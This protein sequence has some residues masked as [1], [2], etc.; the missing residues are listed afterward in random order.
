M[1][2]PRRYLRPTSVA[3]AV[4]L[5]ADL[6]PA[7]RPVAGGT[8]LV[9]A[10]RRGE[11]AP[12][13]LVDLTGIPE[14][15]ALAE[16]GGAVRVG[17]CVTHARLAADPLVGSRVPLLALAA[18]V[19]GSAQIRNLGTLG[20]NVVNASVAADTP[21]ALAALGA[22]AEIAGPG[23]VRR[24]S[25]G[26]LV[27]GPGRTALGHA[28]ILTA[29]IVPLPG[30]HGAAFEKV[31]RRWAVSIA[32]LSV[33]VAADPARGWARI[34]LGGVF[35]SPRRIPGAETA[36][37]RGFDPA[38]AEEAGRAAEEAVR[39]V[40]GGRPSMAYKLPVVRGLVARTALEAAARARGGGS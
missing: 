16:E 12:E 11:A 10:L 33:A 38:S 4:G 34:S 27:T 8:D 17:A 26:D 31:G 14:L 5:L 18:R 25:L 9:V 39:A 24:V 6:G 1:T 21:P 3:E 13:A 37:A 15:R 30:P 22:A 23:G 40:S 32:R 2:R 36:L 29:L 35:P 20:G 7:A 19:V 28:E